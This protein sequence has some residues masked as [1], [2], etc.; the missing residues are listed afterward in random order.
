MTSGKFVSTLLAALFIAANTPGASW[1]Q[2][3]P[4]GRQPP[5]P[6]GGVATVISVDQP[7]NCLRIRSGPGTSYDVIGCANMGEQ[8]NITGVWTSNNWAQLADNAWVYGP[9]IQTDLRPPLEAYSRI[10]SYVITEEIV[11]DYA[12]WAYLPDYGYLTYW[13]GGLPVYIYDV[14]VWYRFHPWWWHRGHQAWWWYGGHHGRRPWNAAQFRNYV[15]RNAQRGFVRNRADISS[16]NRA[17]SRRSYTTN[18]RFNRNGFLSGPTGF[19]PRTFSNPNRYRLRTF[20]TP[21]AFRSGSLR[22]RHGVIYRQ[23]GFSGG[24]IQQPACQLKY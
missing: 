11:P 21:G 15:R 3:A 23:R 14:N 7:E 8:L 20:S 4:T 13:F 17:R 2:V 12:D 16:F 24:R 22:G 18:R 10:P 19:R 9:Q 1:A 5:Q 6:R